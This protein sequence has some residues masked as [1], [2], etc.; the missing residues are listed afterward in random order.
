MEINNKAVLIIKADDED[1]YDDETESNANPISSSSSSGKNV[2]ALNNQIQIEVERRHIVQTIYEY[3]LNQVLINNKFDFNTEKMKHI[4]PLRK[5]IRTEIKEIFKD[6]SIEQEN[7]AWNRAL[8]R[9]RS[10][11]KKHKRLLLNKNKIINN[12]N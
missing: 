3:K 12:N 10:A 11:R 2:Y 4:G 1:D 5:K 9:I 8:I 7:E 6:Y